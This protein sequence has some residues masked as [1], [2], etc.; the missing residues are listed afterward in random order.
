MVHFRL[1]MFFEKREL[2]ELFGTNYWNDLI[3][4]TS[5]RIYCEYTLKNTYCIELCLKMHS[6]FQLGMLGI[7]LPSHP[8]C[9]LRE[10]QGVSFAHYSILSLAKY[11]IVYPFSSKSPA[12][13]SKSSVKDF[14]S[15]GVCDLG[16]KRGTRLT[17]IK[18]L[19]GARH[20][21]KLWA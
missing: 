14:K 1:T 4:K 18:P 9:G 21:I 8:Q 10:R 2:V 19:V 3:H 16:R 11:G 15:I 6:D 5:E 7:W 13:A 20:W 12:V 17:V